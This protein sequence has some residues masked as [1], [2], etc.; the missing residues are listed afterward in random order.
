MSS[1][2]HG[3]LYTGVTANLPKRA[4]VHREGLM[5]GFSKKYGCKMPDAMAILGYDAMRILADAIKRAGD[6]NGDK[7]RQALASTKD[8][9]GASGSITID[10]DR[11]AQKPIVIL[12]LQDGK[13]NFV[14]SIKP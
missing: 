9:P 8:F 4:Y 2:R 14:T 11:N 13:F 3:T 10:K 5:K 7:I 6:T 12:K 1:K